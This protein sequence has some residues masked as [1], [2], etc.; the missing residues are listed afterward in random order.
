MP[1]RSPPAATPARSTP[2]A[3]RSSSKVRVATADTRREPENLAFLARQ[4]LSFGT[5]T[6]LFF[7]E[8]AAKTYLI[9]PGAPGKRPNQVWWDMV[10][11]DK[12]HVV[13][14]IAEICD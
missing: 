10:E 2:L 11:E 6:V 1:A 12:E 8:D 14:R 7:C 9:E 13:T 4:Q 3:T 5:P